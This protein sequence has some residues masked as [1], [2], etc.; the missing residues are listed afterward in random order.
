MLL[1]TQSRASERERSG[2]RWAS[3]GWR[4]FLNKD[5]NKGLNEGGD[6]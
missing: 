1:F 2:E 4:N 5:L 3:E 6:D